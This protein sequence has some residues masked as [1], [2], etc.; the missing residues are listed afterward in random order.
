MPYLF[1]DLYTISKVKQHTY[2]TSEKDNTQ[3]NK[4]N[5]QVKDIVLEQ[6]DA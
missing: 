2:I 4:D 5:K 3:L 6:E 1:I